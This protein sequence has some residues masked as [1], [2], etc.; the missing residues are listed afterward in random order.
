MQNCPQCPRKTVLDPPIVRR[1]PVYHPQVVDVIHQVEIIREHYCV[2]VPHHV[3][4]YVVK[5]EY[6]F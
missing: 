3:Y 2:P 5:D 1:E 4:Q 6:C